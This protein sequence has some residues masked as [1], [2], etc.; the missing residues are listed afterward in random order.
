M[1]LNARWDD[2]ELPKLKELLN[3]ALNTWDPKDAPK[4]AYELDAKVEKKLQE[5]KVEN[6]A[7]NAS[8]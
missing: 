2:E 3:R 8:T 1:P 5:L 7:P 4:W 6:A